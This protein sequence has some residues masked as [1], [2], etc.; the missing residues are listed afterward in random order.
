MR[1]HLLT[2]FAIA[3]VAAAVLALTRV[4]REREYQEL[5]QDGDLALVRHDIAAAIEAFSGAST[6]KPDAMLA[7]LKRG[8]AYRRKD[9]IDSA[10]RD[11]RK[12]A[13]LDPTAPG[14]QEALGDVYLARGAESLPNAIKSYQ[15]SLT[16]D[17]RSARVQ[18][19]LGLAYYRSNQPAAALA[20]ATQAKQIMADDRNRGASGLSDPQLA[21]THYLL[22]LSLAAMGQPSDAHKE[23][24]QALA[25]DPTLTP[26]REELAEV[27][28]LLGSSTEEIGH[29]W[30]LV[31]AEPT[32]ADRHLA[33]GRAYARVGRTD[34]AVETLSRATEQFPRNPQVFVA[35]SHVWL[36]H[37]IT[38]GDPVAIQKGLEAA[39]QAG[40][41]GTQDRS[42]QM[43]AGLAWLR[44]NEPRR[45]MRLFE[46]AT[47][48]LPVDPAAY[49]HLADAAEQLRL[50]TAAR[51]A[52]RHA[53]ALAS[54]ERTS[55]TARTR[56]LRLGNLSM[57]IGDFE[58]ARKSFL[59]ARQ[60]PNDT[61]AANR[62]AAAEQAITKESPLEQPH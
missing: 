34:Q 51:N 12:A 36:E 30:A 62:L 17:E 9:E 6:L 47:S 59:R 55:A 35:L 18:Y 15:R 27:C 61:L 56:L 2:A 43:L 57:K 8:D 39:R 21:A 28:R 37:A 4:Q 53:D 32:R 3:A 49:T 41:T 42:I 58:D 11:L 38:T 46:Q 23:L 31:R 7:Y 1:R 33:L 24:Q 16:L 26:A 20:A 22:G 29:L 45:A 13:N 14:P 25:K 54:D 19:K 48:E 5:I 10:L 50:W 40:P 52:L 44:A 60:G